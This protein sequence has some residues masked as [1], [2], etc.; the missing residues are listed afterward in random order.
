M[1]IFSKFKYLWPTIA[2]ASLVGNGYMGY[3]LYDRYHQNNDPQK[4]I[5][6]AFNA[7]AKTPQP[8]QTFAAVAVQAANKTNMSMYG[9]T[10]VD[11]ITNPAEMPGRRQ[12]DVHP[13]RKAGSGTNVIPLYNDG[14]ETFVLLGRKYVNPRQRELGLMEHYILLGGYMQP[15]PLETTATQGVKDLEGD[16]KDE[17]EEGI[18]RG[19]SGYTKQTVQAMTVSKK[20]AEFDINL[21]ATAKRELAEEGGLNADYAQDMYPTGTYSTYPTTNEPRLHT[22]V[23]NWAVVYYGRERPN[24]KPGSD[25]AEVIWV[26]VKNITTTGADSSIRFE[27]G[28]TAPLKSVYASMLDDALKVYATRKKLE[29]IDNSNPLNDVPGFGPNKPSK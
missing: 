20:E 6:N 25:I 15:H 14:K 13:Y 28:N 2:S 24:A 22:I 18:L 5:L 8:L 19:E 1:R 7:F 29:V 26:N 4:V 16:L 3:M 17:I 21:R 23:E 11:Q 12:Y 10:L 27:N 9:K